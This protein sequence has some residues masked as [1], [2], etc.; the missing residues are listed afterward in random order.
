MSSMSYANI[1]LWTDL[2][3]VIMVMF[4]WKWPSGSEDE[5]F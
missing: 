2:N 5:D 4:G 1:F 3:Y